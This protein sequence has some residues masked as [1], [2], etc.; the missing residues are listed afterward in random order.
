MLLELTN[1]LKKSID[2]MAKESGQLKKSW[3]Y[4][5]RRTA[6]RLVGKTMPKI[7][8]ITEEIAVYGKSG[9][10]GAA[11]YE[12]AVMLAD[13]GYAVDIFYLPIEKPSKERQQFIID[14]FKGRGVRLEFID[15]EKYCW[16]AG[17]A[18]MR[19]YAAYQHLKACKGQYDFL[20]VHDYKGL[21]FFCCSAKKQGLAFQSTQII[22]QLHGPTRWTKHANRSLFV[23]HDQLQIDFL[24]RGSIARA[25][26]L[27]SPSAYLLGWMEEKKFALPPR[28]NVHVIKNVFTECIKESGG[29]YDRKDKFD[30]REI[31]LFGRH[32][33][34]KGFTTFCDALDIISERLSKKGVAVYFVGGL[35]QINGQ[36][37]GV[38][39]TERA[40]NWSFSYEFRVAFERKDAINFLRSRSGAVVVIPSSE[41]N[42][43]Y[44]VVEALATGCAVVTSI[45]G[46]AKELIHQT[47]HEE[48][49][50]EMEPEALAAR[51]AYLIDNGGQTTR[52]AE[53]AEDVDRQWLA[54]HERSKPAAVVLE[55]E[56]KSYPK[57]V[58]GITHFERPR[59]VIGAIMSVMRQTYPNI[60]LVVVDD[61]SA[62]EE[63]I[64]ALPQI[65]NLIQRVGGRFIRRENGYLGA[66]R[67][68]VAKAT[69]SEYLLFLD[70]DDLLFPN[71]VESLVDVAIKTRAD[72]VNCLNVYMDVSIR[73]QCELMPEAFDGKVSYV[74]LGGPLT[75]SHLANTFGAATALINRSFFDKIGGYTEIKR[76]GYEDYELYVRA[77]QMKAHIEILPEPLY[78]YEVGKPSM[79][80]RTSRI[81]NKQR[82]IE[83]LDISLDPDA[84]RDAVELAA[85]SEAVQDERNF[86][87]WQISI[88]PHRELLEKILATSSNVE[89][90]I[91]ALREYAHEIG[92]PKVAAAWS[93]ALQTSSSG[94]VDTKRHVM[95]SGKGSAKKT[96]RKLSQADEVELVSRL[97]GLIKS[98]KIAQAVELISDTMAN[99]GQVTELL[100][101]FV[102]LIAAQGGVSPELVKQLNDQISESF[103]DQALVLRL[104]GA[105]VSLFVSA[106]IADEA[107]ELI[108]EIEAYESSEYVANYPDLTQ[109]FGDDA[110]ERA[111]QHFQKH[112][113]DEGREGFK[114]LQRAAE[115]VS[116]SVG[117]PVNV[118]QLRHELDRFLKPR[119]KLSAFS[120]LLG[121]RLITSRS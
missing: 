29:R 94:D 89:A 73:G 83:A 31:I 103:V 21:G 19:A 101:E 45:A 116:R 76:V 51:L 93:A 82:V 52:L 84:W 105:L 99:S 92:A 34:R 10:I 115:E 54:F 8:F 58:V 46:G 3:L 86:I 53:A 56:K 64:E 109:V 79:I 72:I 90:H 43:P 32:E 97:A 74:P 33:S 65:E 118:W 102:E 117:C 81:T 80:S 63:T 42:S 113:L 25:D 23:H 114:T 40:K 36:P 98:H 17:G 106:G 41:E 70:D 50:V 100:I 69:C 47:N 66:A 59:K 38:Y 9:G 39:L 107:K 60:E 24:E 48:S 78:L 68:T 16:Q 62:S 12:L 18:T 57:V 4:G 88:S 111:L 5:L 119:K 91:A 28:S 27:V 110:A 121:S 6:Q 104:Q 108:A 37:S 1:I 75:L 30:V 35:G 20:H 13:H 11:I 120:R 44:T 61:G 26:H 2:L 112:G 85:G 71:A 55:T 7:A 49:L 15:P 14:A 87:A 96:V 67:N 95:T 77:A 22:V